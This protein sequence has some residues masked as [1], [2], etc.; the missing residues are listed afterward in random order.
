MLLNLNAVV[1]QDK[2]TAAEG[3]GEA[4]LQDTT[5]TS[6]TAQ[7]AVEILCCEFAILYC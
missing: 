7:V 2:A 3:A 5:R 4:P 6:F 1:L